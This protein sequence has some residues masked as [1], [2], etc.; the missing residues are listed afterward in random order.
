MDDFAAPT[1]QSQ[2]AA[3]T[4]AVRQR[5][6]LSDYRRGADISC[7]FTQEDQQVVIPMLHARI[8]DTL[9]FHGHTQVGCS[10]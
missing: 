10:N 9:Y 3:A 6:D 2:T 8:G 7:G 5:D 1:Q 4:G